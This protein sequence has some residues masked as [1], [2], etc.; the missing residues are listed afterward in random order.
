MKFSNLTKNIKLYFK[1]L[2]ESPKDLIFN[3]SKSDRDQVVIEKY[4]PQIGLIAEEIMLKIRKSLPDFQVNYFGSSRLGISG[5]GDIDLFVEYPKNYIAQA[6]VKLKNLF[7]KPNKI[8]YGRIE[9]K[10]TYRGVPVELVLLRE[11]CAEIRNHRKIFEVLNANSELLR[12][13][14]ELKINLKGC[15]TREYDLRRMEYFNFLLKQ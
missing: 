15:S 7:G 8:R 6:E 14:E 12:K 5:R 10:F 2:V 3:F 4:N 11:N 9:W 1:L 13:Y